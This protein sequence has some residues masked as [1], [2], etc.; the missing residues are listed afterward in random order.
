MFLKK[1]LARKASDLGFGASG[2]ARSRGLVMSSELTLSILCWLH[3]QVGSSLGDQGSFHAIKVVVDFWMIFH[4]IIFYIHQKRGCL[5]Q[6]A[7][8]AQCVFK[9]VGMFGE[10]ITQL[11]WLLPME[12][13]TIDVTSFPKNP[14]YFFYF[15]KS[16]SY[17]KPK[18]AGWDT[19]LSQF[20]QLLSLLGHHPGFYCHCFW[21]QGVL[22]VPHSVACCGPRA[23]GSVR[24]Q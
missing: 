2:S 21:P 10:E 13:L 14:V 9:D 7:V 17:W 4:H 1:W 16:I 20:G 24:R 3:A 15:A 8:C 11:A 19:G 23:S 12:Y 18:Y 22:P 6:W 5:W